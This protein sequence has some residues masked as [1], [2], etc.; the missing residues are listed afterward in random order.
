M[1]VLSRPL[2]RLGYLAWG[3]ALFALKIA[4]DYGV[5]AAF[6]HAYS[7]LFYVSPIDAPLL[8]PGEDVAYW[9]TLAATTLPFAVMGVGLTVRR[10]RDAGMSPA[11]AVLFFTPF[12]NLLFFLAM[13]AAPSR[14]AA[15][16]P[17][18]PAYREPGRPLTVGT[19]ARS[20]SAA[21]WMS[22]VLGAVV[23][24]GAFAVSVGLL[25]SYGAAL[26]IGAPVVGGFA[27]GAFYVRLRPE[28]KFAEAVL[29]SLLSS[30]LGVAG[31]LLTAGEG[32][33]CI[34]MVL[35]LFLLPSLLGV[36]VGF[37]ACQAMPPRTVD[38]TIAGAMLLL[39]LLMGV[40]HLNPLPP[41]APE[42]VTTELTIDAPPERV[43]AAV[44]EV[45][46]MEKPDTLPFTAGIAYPIRATLDAPRVG[47]VRRCEFSTGMALETVERWD[48]PRELVFHIDT[49]PDP[50]VEQTLWRGPRQPHLDGYVR[51]QR[52]QFVLEPLAGGRTRLVARSWYTVSITPETYWRVWSDEVI[53]AIHHR[54]MDHAKA[55]AEAA[56]RT[57]LAS[58]GP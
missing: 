3:V 38:T 20:K 19:P 53:H 58:T 34:M 1:D 21:L 27:T 9:A 41:L 6:H 37:Y 15:H 8:R 12:A 52:G 56:A 11:F 17:A 13:V 14:P 50:M 26:M 55:R 16:V 23:A 7:V 42:P 48:P 46:D 24:L 22:A 30:V 18:Q 54:V 29:A 31:L 49:Q 36:F 40:E 45:A 44:A 28:G 10:L 4:V 2:S 57:P 33:V 5:A 43:W 51:N 35:P 25:R 47:A 32:A 39:P